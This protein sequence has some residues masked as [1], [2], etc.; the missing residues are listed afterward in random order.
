MNFKNISDKTVC[1]C[2]QDAVQDNI[3]TF[4]RRVRK[5]DSLNDSDFRNHIERGKTPQNEDDCEEV[6]G[7]YGLSFELWNDESSKL[8]MEKYLTTA[9]FKPRDKR[10][11]CVVRFLA[12]SGYVKYTPNQTEYNEYHYDFYKEDS[13][14]ITKLELVEMIPLV[15]A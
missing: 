4:V 13:F 10:N 2:F 15:V 8:L 1:D 5:S 11:L 7:L 14:N 12:E 6:C 3:N 9:T